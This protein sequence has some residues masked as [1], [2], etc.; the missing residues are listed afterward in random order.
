MNDAVAEAL[1]TSR[2]LALQSKRLMLQSAERRMNHERIQRLRA[3]AESAQHAYR[4]A[5]LR[6]GSPHD[7]DYW[8]VVYGRLIEMGR[9]LALKLNESRDRLQVSPDIAMLD[10]MVD[11]WGEC[12]R[13]AMTGVGRPA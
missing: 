8:V 6:Y 5:M 10:G 1:I 12:M 3:E 11:R 4:T 13:T 9:V 7:R 2:L